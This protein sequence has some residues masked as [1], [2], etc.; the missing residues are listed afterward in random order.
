MT[1]EARL[2][3]VARHALLQVPL[4]LP[5]VMIRLM[6]GGWIGPTLRVK[7]FGAAGH[8]RARRCGA[9]IDHPHALVAAGR[10][11]P[12]AKPVSSVP[13]RCAGWQVTQ[14]AGA[15]IGP[16][17]ALWHSRHCAMRGSCARVARSTLY[18]P[19]W[20]RVQVTPRSTWTR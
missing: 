17:P 2:L 11:T 19:R 13:S 15:Y 16:L 7:R 18:T 4:R 5:R 10:K 14:R 1:L 8:E 20:Q 9:R 3:A 12:L 6:R